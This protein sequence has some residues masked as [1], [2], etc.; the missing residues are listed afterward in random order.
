MRRIIRD[1]QIDAAS[2]C[3]SPDG[4]RNRKYRNHGKKQKWVNGMCPSA[5]CKAKCTE[6]KYATEVMAAASVD[7]PSCSD[8]L[9]LP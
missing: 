5:K 7:I 8:S 2:R 3:F 9:M 4:D 6:P 1:R